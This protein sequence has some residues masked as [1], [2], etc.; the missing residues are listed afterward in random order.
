[1]KRIG[2][3]VNTKDGWIILV[4]LMVLVNAL[5]SSVYTRFDLTSEK[6]YTLTPGTRSLIR[7]LD[8]PVEVEVFL[9]GEFPS[10]FRKLA[11]STEDFLRL[12]KEENSPNVR[13]RF[14]SPLD[15]I[16]GTEIAYA[17]SLTAMGAIP[18]NLTVQKQEG[19][20]SNIIYPVALLRYK[21]RQTLVNLYPGASGRISQ[22][23]INGAEAMMEYQFANALDKI[24]RTTRPSV[25]YAVANGEP[26]DAR[27]ADM[28]EAVRNE[29]DFRV[30]DM[31]QFPVIPDEMDVLLIVKPTKQFT[32]DQKFKIDQ[33]I[34]RGGRLLCFIDGLIAEQDSLSGK[35]ETIAYDRNLNLTDMF[36]RYGLRINTDLV[37]DLQSDV[38]PFVVG[39]SAENPQFEFLKWNYYPL[40]Q[41]TGLKSAGHGYVAGKFVNSI[42]TIHVEGI[43]KT[44]LLVSSSNS[45]IISTPALISLNENRTA[46]R[47]ELFTRNAIPV[48]MLLEGSFTSL[49]RNRAT[50][51]QRDSLAAANLRF[52]P[53]SPADAKIIVVA[54]GDI[55]LNDLAPDPE[56]RQLVPLRMGWN[57]YTYME[58]MMEGPGARY[59]IPV[60]NRD[61]F[62]NCL[63][64]MVNSPAVSE[65]R[66]K[67]IVLRLLDATALKENRNSWV[68]INLVVPV[69]LVILCGMIFQYVRR[70]KYA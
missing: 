46:P 60:S 39:G 50:A 63:E 1:M 29:Y 15:A 56:T 32:E 66:N 13:Y 55:V 47:D 8:S 49:Y 45:R 30:F 22:E 10:G 14:T 28:V 27:T 5:A 20:S 41:G 44:P 6:R 48:A 52:E 68:M 65:S 51:A 53:N 70:R 2:N 21:D 58:T 67:E 17:D 11:N 69:V 43:E 64:Y 25:G 33:Y 37:M 62:L 57:R 18:I 31:D 12:L 34:M 7:Q 61:F 35:I 4:V 36:F 19:Q 23:E 16:P 38:L 59:F 42:D 3:W 9:K 40:L 26:T 24:T 54:D